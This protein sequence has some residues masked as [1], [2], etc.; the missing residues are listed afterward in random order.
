MRYASVGRFSLLALLWG[1]GFFWVKLSGEGFSPV[2]ITL[3]RL[4]LGAAVLLA[5]VRIQGLRLPKDR[6][7][8]A[9]FVVAAFVANALPYLL[10]ALAEQSVSSS[11]AGALNATTPLWALVF[12]YLIGAERQPRPLLI[13]GL[14][15]GFAGVVI[16]LAPWD[17]AVTGSLAGA[18]LCLIASASYGLSY[19]YMA[20]FLIPRQ[21]PPL[22]LST[23]QLLAASG[24]L[25]I[26]TPFTGLQ[27]VHLATK[28]VGALVVLGILGTGVAYVLNYRII[29]DD[30]PMAASAVTYLLPVVAVVLGS[31]L[32][33]ESTNANLLVGGAI[34]L[35]A[36]AIVRRANSSNPDARTPSTTGRSTTRTAGSELDV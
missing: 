22:V 1:S 31:V 4:V 15:L 14:V 36:V 24:L 6:A 18:A 35:V 28:P 34:V 8:W 17:E 10:F 21:L 7:I 3:V 16:V 19:I 9:H 29:A 27:T 12:G 20:R 23:G 25:L 2:Q 33:T 30:G 26:V 32:L 13:F 5:V 11:L